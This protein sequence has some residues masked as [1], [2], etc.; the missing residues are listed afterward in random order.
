MG[1]KYHGWSNDTNGKLIKVPQMDG[2]EGFDK[3]EN[4]SFA[5]QIYTTDIRLKSL[6]HCVRRF[7]GCGHVGKKAQPDAIVRGNHSL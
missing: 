1:C 2:V 7:A 6:I 5:I 3:S 4:P